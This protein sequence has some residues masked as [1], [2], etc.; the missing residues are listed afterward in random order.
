VV[1]TYFELNPI[2]DVITCLY[3]RLAEGQT[4]LQKKGHG[5]AIHISDFISEEDGQLLLKDASGAIV[6]D[7]CKIIYPG[8]KR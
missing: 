2:S 3:S 7:A 5:C 1:C 4:I 8:A 6:R